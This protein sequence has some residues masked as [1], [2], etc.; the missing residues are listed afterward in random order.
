MSIYEVYA[1]DENYYIIM[2]YLS[3]GDILKKI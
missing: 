1:D 2:E 3:G